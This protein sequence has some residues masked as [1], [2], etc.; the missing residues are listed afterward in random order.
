MSMFGEIHPRDKA[1]AK[2][3]YIY[4]FDAARYG[5]SY[6]RNESDW[7]KVLTENNTIKQATVYS[8]SA[9]YAKV[10]PHD[11]TSANKVFIISDKDIADGMT[12]AKYW[13]GNK[14][15]FE[16]YGEGHPFAFYQVEE[17]TWDNFGTTVYLT[18]FDD[19]DSNV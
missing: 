12:D 15:T 5:D 9:D 17:V 2:Y 8:E 13:N 4:P 18:I 16:Y 7:S 11:V 19:G 6:N 14:E 3:L 10:Y 1:S